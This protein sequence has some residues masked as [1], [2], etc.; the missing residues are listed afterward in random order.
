MR[1]GGPAEQLRKVLA[2]GQW[3]EATDVVT[4]VAKTI[5]PGMA[6]RAFQKAKGSDTSRPAVDQI[7]MGQGI[8]ARHSLS[9]LTR[10]GYL[11]VVGPKSKVGHH[12]W[13]TPGAT[14]VRLISAE[15]GLISLPD[16]SR[17]L[18]RFRQQGTYL[19]SQAQ[20]TGQPVPPHVVVGEHRPTVMIKRE[21]L[22]QWAAFLGRTRRWSMPGFGEV[23][24]WI[25]YDAHTD[26][27]YNFTADRYEL[28]NDEVVTRPADPIREP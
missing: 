7:W 3:H 22:P 12:D 8:L 1:P 25:P 15:R 2:D 14:K 17:M 9:S 19:V 26:A 21:H 5:P 23:L 24:R 18:G 10:R 13:V 16:V 28:V 20:R 4:K 11:E 27:L 6:Q